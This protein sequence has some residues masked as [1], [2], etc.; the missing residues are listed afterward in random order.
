MTRIAA[1]ALAAALAAPIPAA[2]QTEEEL[3]A[4]A[5]ACL[6]SEAAVDAQ[7]TSQDDEGDRMTR[8]RALA[9]C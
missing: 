4:Q 7:L 8:L 3:Y 2:A 5:V 9:I 6:G 1:I